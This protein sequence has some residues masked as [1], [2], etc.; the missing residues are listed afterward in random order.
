MMRTGSCSLPRPPQP[1]DQRLH[2][3]VEPE[4]GVK[5]ESALREDGDNDDAVT[6]WGIYFATRQCDE[7]PRGGAP[8]LH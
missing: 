7:L 1:P 8:V 6:Q 5:L 4:A 2:H 3:H